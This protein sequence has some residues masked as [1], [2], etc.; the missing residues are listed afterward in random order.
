M[1][2]VEARSDEECGLAYNAALIDEAVFFL[3]SYHISRPRG[4][5]Q[6]VSDGLKPPR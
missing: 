5:P 4:S 6:S 2:C 3:S 1:H